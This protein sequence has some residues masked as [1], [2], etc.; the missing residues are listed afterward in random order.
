[1]QRTKA[2]ILLIFG[3]DEGRRRTMPMDTRRR[4]REDRPANRQVVQI[5]ILGIRLLMAI[6]VVLGLVIQILEII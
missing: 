1:M 3:F 4:S 2:W 6:A 5:L